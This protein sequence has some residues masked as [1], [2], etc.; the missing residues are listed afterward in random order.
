MIKKFERVGIIGA[1]MAGLSCARRLAKTGV[2]PILF[3][4][5][6]GV[7]GRLATRLT[8][9]GLQFDHGAQYATGHSTAFLALLAEIEEAGSAGHWT[10]DGKE[11]A[12]GMPGMNGLARYMARGLEIRQRAEVM[13]IQETSDGWELC[14]SG[15]RVRVGRLVITTPVAQAAALLGHDHKLTRQ[16]RSVRMTPCLTL[17]A[18]F[19]ADAPAPFITRRD[20]DDP[21]PWIALD[22]SKPGRITES[23]W[24]AQAGPTWSAEHLEQRRS[25]V[26]QKMLKMLSDR[27]GAKPSSAI[28]SVA[29]RW[30]YAGVAQALGQPFVRNDN[31]SLYLGGDW[32]LHGR[33]EGAW[34]S[35]TAI[36]ADLLATA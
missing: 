34:S 16:I 10:V 17:M 31:A 33:I 18:A 23:C 3:D 14:V 36:A 9:S 32:C 30:R 6:R 5:G 2:Q 12:V 15:Q 8:D 20:P 19:T 35:G 27:I 25:D 13:H 29:H 7:G 1:G 21:I 28:H 24:V 26:A 22:S 4:K 11:R